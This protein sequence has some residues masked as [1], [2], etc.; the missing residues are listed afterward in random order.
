LTSKKR[1]K[2]YQ[3]KQ[4]K[5]KIM[6]IDGASF[7]P[8]VHKKQW[9]E[10]QKKEGGVEPNFFFPRMIKRKGKKEEKKTPRFRK[11]P[12]IS[13]VLPSAKRGEG[14]RSTRKEKKEHK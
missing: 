8:Q 13:I 11:L 12:R 3:K 14:V 7:C 1:K 4:K 10:P 9:K 6:E 5:F 2:H